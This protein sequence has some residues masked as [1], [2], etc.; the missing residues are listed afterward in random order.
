[1]DEFATIKI[2]RYRDPDGNPT[3]CA[4][5]DAKLC[6]FLGFRSLGMQAVCMLGEQVDLSSRHGEMSFL[7][8]HARC[9]V[10]AGESA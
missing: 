8:P 6:A 4:A 10:W 9:R 3:C 2:Q 7:M 1:M 5:Y